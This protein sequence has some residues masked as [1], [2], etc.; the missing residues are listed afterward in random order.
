MAAANETFTVKIHQMGGNVF[1]LKNVRMNYSLSLVKIRLLR[2][3]RKTLK[4]DDDVPVQ[5]DMRLFYMMDQGYIELVSGSLGE[6][7]IHV[8]DSEVKL[9]LIIRPITVYDTRVVGTL[10]DLFDDVEHM[11]DVPE[12]TTVVDELSS[13]LNFKTIYILN[14]SDNKKGIQCTVMYISVND[15]MKQTILDVHLPNELVFRLS[16]I[17]EGDVSSTLLY[18]YVK[19]GLVFVENIGHGGRRKKH[20]RRNRRTLLKKHRKNRTHRTHRK[21]RKN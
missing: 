5:D 11:V 15:P 20:T 2:E 9:E 18:P 19:Q 17:I 6:H 16:H 8:I 4:D 7:G 21:H 14:E 3:Y 12:N 10:A 1:E 13:D